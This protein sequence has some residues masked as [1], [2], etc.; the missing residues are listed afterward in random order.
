[1]R[2]KKLL[3]SFGTHCISDML[4]FVHSADLIREAMTFIR[5]DTG[6]AAASGGGY[7]DRIMAALIGLFALHQA[8]NQ[9][10]M[11]S[12]VFQG[13]KSPISTP[14]IKAGE[15]YIDREFAQILVYGKQD[16]YEQSWM[17]Y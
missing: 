2:T 15:Q 7:D 5:D 13:E 4:I 11:D 16:D 17:N 1:M 6:G 3:I 14:D 12:Y 9:E 8:I 10:P